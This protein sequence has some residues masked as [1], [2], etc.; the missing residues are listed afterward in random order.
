LNALQFPCNV[1]ELSAVI[2][3]SQS[4]SRGHVLIA[5]HPFGGVARVQSATQ[6]SRTRRQTEH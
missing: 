3:F 1:F 2:R 5:N 4:G 6:A